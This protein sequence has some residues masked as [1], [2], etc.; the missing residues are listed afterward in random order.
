[1]GEQK[2]GTYQ[3]L[4]VHTRNFLVGYVQSDGGDCGPLYAVR[5]QE[6]LLLHACVAVEIIANPPI[7]SFVYASVICLASTHH[8]SI[9]SGTPEY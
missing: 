9:H 1:M 6:C 7:L 4:E 2:F 5:Q 8:P 3:W